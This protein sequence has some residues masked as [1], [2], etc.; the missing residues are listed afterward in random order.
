MLVILSPAK[1]MDF[2]S[3]HNNYS[4]T[5]CHYAKEM[6][7]LVK[8]MQSKSVGE[9]ATMMSLSRSLAE[10]N[11]NRYQKFDS[12]PK[13]P[14]LLAFRGDVYSNMSVD[15]YTKQDMDFAQDH[16]RILSGLYGLLRPLDMIRAYRLEMGTKVHT[17]FGETLYDYWGKK[18]TNAVNG[19]ILKDDKI[20]INLASTE[21]SSVINMKEVNGSVINVVFKNSNKG[22]Y[23]V[24]GILAKRARGLMADFIIKNRISNIEDLKKFNGGNY[25]FQENISSDKEFVFY[26]Q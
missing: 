18:V 11:Y 19:L 9:L 5:E 10:L 8:I 15:S 13:M 4:G 7:Q 22:S 12:S 16:V 25:K 23:K 21:Y 26:G 2:K 17:D 14:S 1:K 24:I 6:A 20:L 3:V